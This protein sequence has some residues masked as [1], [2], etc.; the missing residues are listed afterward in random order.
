[1]PDHPATGITSRCLGTRSRAVKIIHVNNM[2]SVGRSIRIE[3]ETFFR[4]GS[5]VT[6]ACC[7]PSVMRLAS[8]EPYNGVAGLLS[9]ICGQALILCNRRKFCPRCLPV[10][11]DAVETVDD[12][13]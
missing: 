9:H 12:G 4:S 6:L 13:L 10:A 11:I 8:V 3:A 5:L 1:M 2:A 7:V